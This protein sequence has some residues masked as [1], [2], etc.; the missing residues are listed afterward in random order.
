MAA[1]DFLQPLFHFVA[2]LQFAN[3]PGWGTNDCLVDRRLHDLKRK[4]KKKRVTKLA[5]IDC[6]ID[7]Q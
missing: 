4:K 5:P 3:V 2:D 7:E 6:S 1:G